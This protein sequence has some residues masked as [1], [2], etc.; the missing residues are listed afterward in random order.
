MNTMAEGPTTMSAFDN[1]PGAPFRVRI[2]TGTT[3]SQDRHFGLR[4]PECLAPEGVTID[5]D[6]VFE[7]VRKWSN[8]D[9]YDLRAP[10]FG[11]D[12]GS[13]HG[14]GSISVVGRMGLE[15]VECDDPIE[16][17]VPEPPAVTMIAEDDLDLSQR[18][19]ARL[20]ALIAEQG[21][22]ADQLSQQY[23]SGLKDALLIVEQEAADENA[24]RKPIESRA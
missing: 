3:I 11:G 12:Y 5:P 7:A 23:V 10:G 4:W 8:R 18:I 1:G 6:M 9:V 21:H 13:G 24:D 17:S 22:S 16:E 2:K 15:I 20:N 14:N 19:I